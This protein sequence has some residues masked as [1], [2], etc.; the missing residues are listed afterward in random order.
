MPTKSQKKNL[1][2]SI[3]VPAYHEELI[4]E[5]SLR[6]LYS[7]LKEEGLFHQTEVVV[8]TA[9]SPDNTS[10]I[11]AQEIKQFKYFKHVKPG[12][13]VGKGRDVKTGIL[14]ASGEYVL[15]MDAD[16]ATPLRYVKPAF[17]KLGKH[18]LI[19][20][21]RDLKIIHSDFRKYISIF[22]NLLIRI[23]LLPGFRDTQC[24]FKAFRRDVANTILE[25]SKIVG[26]GFDFEILKI[27]KI[28]SLSIN[29]LKINGWHDPKIEA[30]LTGVSP[31]HASLSTLLELLIVKLNSIR[32][33]YKI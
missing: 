8:V 21:Q 5:N 27:A 20:G 16:L 11:V 4:I 7:F 25:K 18:D 9:D 23:T 14:A 15:F 17:A 19:I 6:K 10:E 22:S 30:G 29:T 24:G 2:Y 1:K 26:W 31:I 32:G 13:K 3:V 33:V 12:I 28:N